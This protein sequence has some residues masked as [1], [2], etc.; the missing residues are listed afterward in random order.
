MFPLKQFEFSMGDFYKKMKGG[1]KLKLYDSILEL[2][3]KT[4]IVKLNKLPDQM[5]RSLHK[6]GIL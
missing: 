4:P 2:I 1:G 6:I 5:G 3:G